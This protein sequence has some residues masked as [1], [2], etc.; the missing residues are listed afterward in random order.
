MDRVC[1]TY[2][3]DEKCV[4]DFKL[5]PEGK[6]LFGIPRLGWKDNIKMNVKGS[7]CDV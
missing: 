6:R 7:V 1:R 5:K 2:V 4:Q 3:R